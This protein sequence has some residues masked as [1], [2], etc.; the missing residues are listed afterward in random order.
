[1]RSTSR[2]PTNHSSREARDE[3]LDELN[4]V[5]MAVDLKDYGTV[6]CCY[7][8]AREEKLYFMED[9]KFGGADVVENCMF[10]FYPRL[11]PNSRFA[12]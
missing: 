8:V 2:I 1:M 6:G 7:Y 9:I 4:E 11:V 10:H 3:D 12:Q 5:I